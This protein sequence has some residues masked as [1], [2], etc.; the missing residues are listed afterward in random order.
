MNV[1]NTV[2]PR[3]ALGRPR[4]GEA[5]GRIN[6]LLDAATEVFL[7]R[8]FAGASTREIARRAGASKETLYQRFPS[9]ASLFAAL[10]ERKSNEVLGTM[11]LSQSAD[12]SP[13]AA[14]AR[15][16][17]RLLAAMLHP[18]TQRLHQVVVAEARDFP[19]LAAAFW[20]KGPGL[21][22]AILKDYLLELC[23][24]KRL[25]RSE[26][27]FASEQFLGALLGGVLLR[28]TLALPGLLADERAM[29]AWAKK[30]AAAFVRAHLV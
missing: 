25:Q 3:G 29:R 17:E 1:A 30:T 27:E 9:K 2:R 24:Q 19:E 20:A 16:G 22:R 12:A 26:V 6:H 8:G 21:G 18:E 5:D 7:E 15:F 10:I 28:S 14:L 23:R 11:E 4:L 13:E